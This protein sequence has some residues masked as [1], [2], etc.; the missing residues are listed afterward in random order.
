MDQGEIFGIVGRKGAGKTSF[1]ELLAALL[2]PTP[3]E[4][5][6]D[7]KVEYGTE[8]IGYLEDEPYFF[9]YLTV[10]E[11]IHYYYLLNNRKI[12]RQESER[13]LKDY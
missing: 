10:Q 5:R 7:G 4:I 3:G 8:K 2:K 9:E 11:I 6:I 12:S 13:S 1:L